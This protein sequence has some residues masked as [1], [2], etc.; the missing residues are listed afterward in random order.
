[1]PRVCTRGDV[2]A[3]KMFRFSIG[4]ATTVVTLSMLA[5]PIGDA[6]AQPPDKKAA[7]AAAAAARRTCSGPASGAGARATAAPAPMVRS[8]PPPQISRQAPVVRSA[9]QQHTVRPQQSAPRIATHARHRR[10][11]AT[12]PRPARPTRV[13]RRQQA[14]Q[15]RQQSVQSKTIAPSAVTN[16]AV[17]KQ[18]IDAALATA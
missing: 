1:M 3:Q 13:E 7:P 15:Q 5:A 4:L 8:A 11:S 18:H 6:A 10:S 2:G 14:V 16:N 12:R 17:A 9:P